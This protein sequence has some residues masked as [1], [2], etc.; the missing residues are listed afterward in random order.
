[1]TADPGSSSTAT[2]GV[3]GRC[4]SAT[5]GST[6]PDTGGSPGRR[7]RSPV[8]GNI[9]ST[10]EPGMNSRH[11]LRNVAGSSA[12]HTVTMPCSPGPNA[13]G[14]NA[15]SWCHGLADPTTGGL[16]HKN[17]LTSVP[18]RPPA[19]PATGPPARSSA[20]CTASNSGT[21]SW[22]RS[23]DRSTPAGRRCPAARRPSR[24]CR[25]PPA[26]NARRTP[27]GR[28]RA[29]PDRPPR[30]AAGPAPRPRKPGQPHESVLPHF[31]V[32]AVVHFSLPLLA[33]GG[34][35][36]PAHITEMF[37]F[38]SRVSRGVAVSCAPSVCFRAVSH[39]GPHSIRTGERS[40]K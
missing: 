40:D 8:C 13:G 10:W 1:M 5:C 15:M 33:S 22:M 3:D 4:P 7:S 6:A 30:P 25:A 29:P 31:T 28:G 32:M 37:M 18:A 21:C 16:A 12:I 2:A 23:A 24:R 14:A 9:P 35:A 11:P 39:S 36:P 27:R 34:G 19:A 38:N 26:R 20:R 17:A